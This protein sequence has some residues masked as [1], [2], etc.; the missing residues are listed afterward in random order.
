M[1]EIL[2]A[3]I[4]D[5]NVKAYLADNL[6]ARYYLLLSLQLLILI[7]TFIYLLI[8]DSYRYW[9]YNTISLVYL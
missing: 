9:Y 2:I 6:K 3:S 7:N 5:R 8:N 1:G 4:T